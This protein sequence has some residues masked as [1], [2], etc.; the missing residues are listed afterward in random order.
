M[1]EQLTCVGFHADVIWAGSGEAEY[2][3]VSLVDAHSE[4]YMTKGDLDAWLTNDDNY[5][6]IL[7][8]EMLTNHRD[9]L[10]TFDVN[11]ATAITT[12][13]QYCDTY[14]LDLEHV[15]SFNEYIDWKNS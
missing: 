11:G 1:S 8:C 14:G 9:I 7:G 4:H 15:T 13:K 2:I 6:T 10:W 12:Y 5:T 3:Y